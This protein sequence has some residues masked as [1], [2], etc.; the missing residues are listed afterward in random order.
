VRELGADVVAA[1]CRR[2][3]EGGAPALHIYTLNR[4]QATLAVLGRLG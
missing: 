1:L 3:V 4:A 2:L